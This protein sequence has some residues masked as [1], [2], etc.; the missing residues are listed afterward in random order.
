MNAPSPFF[1]IVDFPPPPH[2]EPGP[3]MF[4]MI[5]DFPPSWSCPPLHPLMFPM[6]TRV[7]PA[8]AV[9]FGF[10]RHGHFVSLV[11]DT[12]PSPPCLRPPLSLSGIMFRPFLLIFVGTCVSRHSLPDRR[13]PPCASGVDLNVLPF[14]QQP[15][16]SSPPD[17]WS[18]PSILV[19]LIGAEVNFRPCDQF[20]CPDSPECS[21]IYF[22]GLH[23]TTTE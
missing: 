12:F 8:L 21:L 1:F 9:C 7:N 15:P 14:P 20:H 13:F 11:M 22:S 6:R 5:P 3:R 2:C 19:P 18:P 17:G 4:L 10:L 16:H 23:C